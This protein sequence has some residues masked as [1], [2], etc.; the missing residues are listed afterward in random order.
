MLINMIKMK[1]IYCLQIARHSVHAS[2]RSSCPLF[3]VYCASSLCLLSGE[4][5]VVMCLGSVVEGVAYVTVLGY[6]TPGQH[7]SVQL[8]ETIR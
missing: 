8:K 2:I 1:H 7:W 4:D 5:H 3:Q 6:D